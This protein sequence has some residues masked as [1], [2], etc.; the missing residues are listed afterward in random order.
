MKNKKSSQRGQALVLIAL[1]VVGLV[2]FTALAIDGGRI[3]SDRRHSQNASD[4]AALAAALALT[5]ENA[6]WKDLGFNRAVDNGYDPSDGFT[7]IDV[8][9]CSELPLIV[10]GVTLTCVGKGLPTAA[11]PAEYVH[12]HIKS[13][14][15]LFFARVVGW[16][17]AINNTDSVVHA[18]KQE[19]TSLFPGYAIVSTMLNCPSSPPPFEVSGNSGTT[20]INAGI[21]VNSNCDGSPKPA[22]DQSGGSEVETDTGVCVVGAAEST[23]TIPPPSTNCSPIDIAAYTL[24]NPFCS[25]EGQIVDQG[26]NNYTATPGNYGDGYAFNSI[27][28]VTPSGNLKL[29]KGIYCL[30]NGIRLNSTWTITTDLDGDGHDPATEG[31]FFFVPGGEL[32]FN[33]SSDI[34]IHAISSTVDDFPEEFVNFLIYVPSTNTSSGKVNITGGNGSQFTGTILAPGSEITLNGGSGAIGLNSQ[35]IGYAVKITGNGTLNINYNPEDNAITTTNP[36]LEQT[37]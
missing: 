16:E 28:D 12:V 2:G 17:T 22:Y 25:H 20:V 29:L 36:G 32:T 15:D 33:G 13:K 4:T 1:A 9:L 24:P 7:A 26:S 35:I 21:L 18:K 34:N 19:D 8:H 10:N 11:D 37:E 31:V 30:H 3:F 5:R 14:V 27:D 23:N 6:N